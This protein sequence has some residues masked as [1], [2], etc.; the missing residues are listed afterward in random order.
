MVEEGQK[1]VDVLETTAVW[2][3]VT[4]QEDKELVSSAIKE[5][6]ETGKYP[7]NLWSE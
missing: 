7:K 1:Q 2:Y 4:Y 3:G 5:L 6:V